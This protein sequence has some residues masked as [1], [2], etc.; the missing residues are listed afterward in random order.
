MT[1]CLRPSST[2][3]SGI[4]SNAAEPVARLISEVGSPPGLSLLAVVL[5]VQA[6][7]PAAA[8]RWASL[9]LLLT[10]LLPMAYLIW[11]VRRG[12]VT[13]LHLPRRRERYRPLGFALVTGALSAAALIQGSAPHLLVLLALLQLAQVVIFLAFTLRWKVSAHCA[14]ASGLTILAVFLWGPAGV[15]LGVCVP[16]IAWSRVYL[17][18]HTLHQTVAGTLIGTVLWTTTFALYGA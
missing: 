15:L 16:L 14:A 7:G 8:W 5:V 17:S 3:P 2:W 9:H 13:D 6:A 11:L 1:V 18:R 10:I 12:R 4:C